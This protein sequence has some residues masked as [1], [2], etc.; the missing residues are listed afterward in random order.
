MPR[1]TKDAL[2]GLM[3][4]LLL[5]TE[6]V[7]QL[8]LAATSLRS[9]LTTESMR[10]RRQAELRLAKVVACISGLS[11][12]GTEALSPNFLHVACDGATFR[13]GS[14]EQSIETRPLLQRLLLALVEA[15][16]TGLQLSVE[17]LFRKGWPGE[18]ASVRSMRE[19][20]YASVAQLRSHG[21]GDVLVRGASGY[22]L[23][24]EVIVRLASAT[25]AESPRLT[26]SW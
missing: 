3:G 1:G 13:I 6:A 7:A 11:E 25:E 8:E 9:G 16:G 15:H 14:A 20:V 24:S 10:A 26:G 19:R 22:T 17:D 12:R 2:E 18:R 23:S 4:A 5:A 21:L